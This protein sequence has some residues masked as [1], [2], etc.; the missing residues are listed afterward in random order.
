MANLSKFKGRTNRMGPPPTVEEAGDNLKAPE[1][2]PQGFKEPTSRTKSL[3][4]KVTPEFYRTLKI[5]AAQDGLKIVELLEKALE[6][7]QEKY[8]R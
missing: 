6:A 7:Y 8:P 4:T 2:A 3:A 1:H 5:L